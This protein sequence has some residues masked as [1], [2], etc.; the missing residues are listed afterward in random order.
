MTITV[1]VFSIIR[2]LSRGPTTVLGTEQESPVLR[3]H[4][5]LLFS[6]A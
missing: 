3:H 4:L 1:A 6:D 2:F 5:K